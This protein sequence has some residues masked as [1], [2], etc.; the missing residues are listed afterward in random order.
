MIRA[1]IDGS[2]RQVVAQ[3]CDELISPHRAGAPVDPNEIKIA[4]FVVIQVAP[5]PTG[6]GQKGADVSLKIPSYLEFW[7]HLARW[8]VSE[9]IPAILSKEDPSV[10]QIRWASYFH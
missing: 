5:G 6:E 8:S 7:R 10:S 9:E 2:G 3:V 1:L 4:P